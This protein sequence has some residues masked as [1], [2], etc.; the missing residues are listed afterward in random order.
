MND[1]KGRHF[2]GEIVL[3]GCSV[4]TVGTRSVTDDL[5]AM[6][7]RTPCRQRSTMSTGYRSVQRFAPEM[8]KRPCRLQ[9]RR[10]QSTS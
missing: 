10:P 4:G 1:F 9:W 5:E 7:D 3:C 2:G 6:I 8:E